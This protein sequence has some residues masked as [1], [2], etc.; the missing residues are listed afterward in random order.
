M[1][2]ATAFKAHTDQSHPG[3]CCSCRY[4]LIRLKDRVKIA[5]NWCSG[6]CRRRIPLRWKTKWVLCCSLF[7]FTS[8]RRAD[9]KR[10]NVQQEF[11]IKLRF[12]RR[13]V[14]HVSAWESVHLIICIFL[15]CSGVEIAYVLFVSHCQTVTMVTAGRGHSFSVS[16]RWYKGVPYPQRLGETAA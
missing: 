15:R 2:N 3:R 5:Q 8:C 6:I 1:D 7:Q 13:A 14:N 16:G 10:E 12:R 9:V 4:P 11:W